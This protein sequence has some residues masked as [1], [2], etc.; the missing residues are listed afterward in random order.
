MRGVSGTQRALANEA[1]IVSALAR[2]GVVI[3]QAEALSARELVDK[4]FGAR[5]VISTEGSQLSHALFT[6][7]DDGGILVIQPP[8]RFFTS[9]MD[10][11]RA[12]E[13]RF[14]IAVGKPAE[15]GFYLPLDDL[16]RS[17]EAMEANV[18]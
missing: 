13:L 6:L 5:L 7:R 16:L 1:E 14:G 4:L 3:L 10:W 12:L 18:T 8:D 2:R 11:A 15:D 9:H 17:I